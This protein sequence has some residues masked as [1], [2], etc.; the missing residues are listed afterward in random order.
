MQF[1][2]NKNEFLFS[3]FLRFLNSDFIKQSIKTKQ[4]YKN[5]FL[6][7]ISVLNESRVEKI[8]LNEEFLGVGYDLNIH[9]DDIKFLNGVC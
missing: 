3:D 1:K 4:Q 9:L 6:R 2:N 5:I 8:E 7:T